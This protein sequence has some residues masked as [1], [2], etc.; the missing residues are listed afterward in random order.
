M[1]WKRPYAREHVTVGYTPA[2]SGES[3]PAQPIADLVVAHE[4]QAW[5]DFSAY[6][7]AGRGTGPR[8][9]PTVRVKNRPLNVLILVAK[10]ASGCYDFSGITWGRFVSDLKRVAHV[11]VLSVGL[12]S[13]SEC[14]PPSCSIHADRVKTQC[15]YCGA[16]NSSLLA[17]VR[18]GSASKLSEFRS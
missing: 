1:P 4:H 8:K 9:P 17:P 16:E 15:S 18:A 2:D 10:V 14:Y 7:A 6:G 3:G 13:N 11:A 5:A 12:R